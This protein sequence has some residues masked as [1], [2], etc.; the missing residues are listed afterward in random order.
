MDERV[1]PVVETP[2]LVLREYAYWNG[3]FH[4]HLQFSLIRREWHPE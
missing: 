4:N 3:E 1:F 2:Q